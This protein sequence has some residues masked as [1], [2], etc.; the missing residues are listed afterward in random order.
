[1]NPLITWDGLRTLYSLPLRFTVMSL[2]P[3]LHYITTPFHWL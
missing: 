3:V 2:V 1:L